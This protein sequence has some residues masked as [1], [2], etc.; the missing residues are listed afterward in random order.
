V[1]A[2]LLRDALLRPS[3]VAI[4]GASADPDKT[5]GR[6]IQFLKQ[7]GFQGAIWPVNP[8]RREVQKLPAYPSLRALPR[9]PDQVYIVLDSDSALAACEEAIELGVPMVGMLANGFSEA[10]P[11]G[12]AREEKCVASCEA[13]ARVCLV[14]I[15]SGSFD[16]RRDSSAPRTRHSQLER[17]APAGSA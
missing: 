17:S 5:S 14:P 2:V 9:T 10:G 6:P 4:V 12:V 15:A 13:R 7:Y 8:R 11:E 3:S 1:S 16:L